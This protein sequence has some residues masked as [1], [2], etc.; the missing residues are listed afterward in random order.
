EKFYALCLRDL[1]FNT[2][3]NIAKLAPAIHQTWREVARSEGWTPKYDMLYADL[4][5]DVKRS[6]EAAARRIPDILALVGLQVVP[7][8]ATAEEE[9]LVRQQIDHHIETLAEEEHKGWMAHLYSEGWKFN[10]LRHDDKHQHDC[11]RPFHELRE[12]DKEK[13]RNSV[14]HY[15]D[16]VREAG[17]K[18]VFI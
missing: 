17:F 18:I 7:G 13:D 11:L 12:K 3:Q 9:S 4:P 5:A 1:P 2:E 6:N 15:T 16:F 14:R 8:E 10:E